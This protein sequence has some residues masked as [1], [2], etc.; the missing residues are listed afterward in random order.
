MLASIEDVKDASEKVE[1]LASG[2]DGAAVVT[3]KQP[4]LLAFAAGSIANFMGLTALGLIFALFI[5][6]SGDLFYDKLVDAFR[7][8]SDK[9]RAKNT[10]RDIERQISR[11]FLTITIINA[12]LGLCV[13]LAM[14]LIGLPNPMLWGGLAF[15]LNF[16]PFVGSLFGAVL[17]AAFGVLSF[18]TL[19][20]GLLP[21]VVY[22]LLTSI[23]AQ[24]VTPTI[25]G[26]RLNMNTVSVFLTVIIWSWLWSVPGALMAVPFLVMLKVICDNVPSMA[27]LGN[28]LGAKAVPENNA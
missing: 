9:R 4:G 7:T 6:A 17:V 8:S 23:E 28:F 2:S 3:V 21:A 15:A 13:G 22:A 27:V 1:E 14:Y 11:Y 26:K 20:M 18:D 5:L 12:G 16:L 10:A 25:L 19:G 24:F